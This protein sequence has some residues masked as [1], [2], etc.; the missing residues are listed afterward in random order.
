MPHLNNEI[1]PKKGAWVIGHA[2]TQIPFISVPF[3][4]FAPPIATSHSGG[5][6]VVVVVMGV[7]VPRSNPQASPPTHIYWVIV[8][9]YI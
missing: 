1:K 5:A 9:S 4:V 7:E 6:L 3:K 2:P 8:I